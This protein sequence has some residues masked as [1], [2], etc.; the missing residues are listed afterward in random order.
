M[1]LCFTSCRWHPCDAQQVAN[2]IFQS[3]FDLWVYA[4]TDWYVSNPTGPHVEH[5]EELMKCK[6][7]PL[8]THDMSQF[9][10]L[11]MVGSE[12]RLCSRG[13]GGEEDG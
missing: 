7:T 10:V 11:K 6:A 3:G 8:H 2:H 1:R 13:R 12:R 9:H 4:G 5:Q